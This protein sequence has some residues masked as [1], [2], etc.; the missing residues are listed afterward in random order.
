MAFPHHDD[1][2]H[3]TRHADRATFHVGRL[4]LSAACPVLD[5]AAEMG[6]PLNTLYLS[7]L[8][9]PLITVRQGIPWRSFPRCSSALCLRCGFSEEF[10]QHA[11]N[12][13]C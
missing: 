13:S 9:V 5:S 3:V 8:A 2:L 11:V 6:N 1:A 4:P 7:T 10:H 12:S